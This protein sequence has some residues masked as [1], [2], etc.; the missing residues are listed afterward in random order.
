M[1]ENPRKQELREQ[2]K[3]IK[4]E[5]KAIEKDEMQELGFWLLSQRTSLGLSQNDIAR[6][7][8]HQQGT[9]QKWEKAK[10]LPGD[11]DTLIK[12]VKDLHL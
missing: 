4:A 3:L 9:W 11:A 2:I 5:I 10:A 8:G 7:L 12:K 6:K 1:F